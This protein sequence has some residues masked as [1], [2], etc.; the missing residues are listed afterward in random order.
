M[1]RLLFQNSR[2][3]SLPLLRALKS[4]GDI[5]IKTLAELSFEYLWL[6]I[7]AGEDVIDPDYSVKCQES[8]SEYFSAMT[9]AEKEALSTVALEAQ[10]RLLAEPDK[11]GYTPRKLVTEEQRAFLEAL[12][13]GDIFDQWG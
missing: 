5:R 3:F 1:P 4:H 8:L 12:A 7:F 13:S 9:P 11:H 2:H 6:V 10:A